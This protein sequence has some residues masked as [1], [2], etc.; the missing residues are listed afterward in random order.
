LFYSNHYYER[1]QSTEF[2]SK[3]KREKERKSQE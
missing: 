1:T 2:I 3:K